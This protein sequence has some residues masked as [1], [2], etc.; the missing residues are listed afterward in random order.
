MGIQNC[1][2]RSRTHRVRATGLITLAVQNLSL[3]EICWPRE[4]QAR[5][6]INMTLDRKSRETSACLSGS[7][8]ND[9]LAQKPAPPQALPTLVTVTA[10]CTAAVSR[11]VGRRPTTSVYSS[12]SL[13]FET[14]C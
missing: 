9:R 2:T 13:S 5:I 3:V 6:S 11:T 1:N 4:T 12:C 14:R 8:V 10:L 7:D